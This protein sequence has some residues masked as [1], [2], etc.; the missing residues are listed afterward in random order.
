LSEALPLALSPYSSDGNHREASVG[1]CGETSSPEI[2][3]LII[4]ELRRKLQNKRCEE[5]GDVRAHL[6]K[7]QQMRN[8][9]ASMGEVFLMAVFE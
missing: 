9:L 6:A 2:S 5:K 4:V 7:L 3:Q 8:D 1:R